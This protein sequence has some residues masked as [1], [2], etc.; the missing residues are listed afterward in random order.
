MG[1]VPRLGPQPHPDGVCA[2]HQRR[3]ATGHRLPARTSLALQP[4]VRPVPRACEWRGRG[5]LREIQGRSCG[6][7]RDP[8]DFPRAGR[9]STTLP[10]SRNRC[11]SRSAG[12]SACWSP[13]PRCSSSRL[14]REGLDLLGNS[15]TASQPASCNHRLRYRTLAAG[16]ESSEARGPHFASRRRKVCVRGRYGNENHL[17]A[18]IVRV[19]HGLP[20]RTFRY[21][22][23]SGLGLAPLRPKR[24]PWRCEALKN[25]AERTAAHAADRPITE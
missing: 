5:T 14:R 3:C 19:H 13:M 16:P 9:Y 6:R 22:R 21:V 18:M 7:D 24:A 12:T 11:S 23:A 15:A 4:V 20:F 25:F 10:Q 2:R 1:R 8:G 17:D